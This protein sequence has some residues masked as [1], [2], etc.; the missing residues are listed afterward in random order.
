ML[1]RIDEPEIFFKVLQKYNL[2]L[3]ILI[4]DKNLEA[5]LLDYYD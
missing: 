5:E 2:K 1:T 3:I 4:F